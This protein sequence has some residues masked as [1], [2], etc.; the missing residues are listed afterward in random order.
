MAATASDTSN[1][2]AH[3]ST[4]SPTTQHPF[5]TAAGRGTLSPSRLSFYLAMDRNF[6]AQAYPFLGRLLA[7]VP[8]SSLHGPDSAVGRKN[9]RI[10]RIITYSLTN[11]VREVEFFGIIAERYGLNLNGWPENKATRDYTA[12]MARVGAEGRIEDGSCSCG[13]W[14][15]C[16]FHY[17][18][19][20][21]RYVGSLMDGAKTGDTTPAVAVL[22]ENWTNP[23]FARFVDDVAELVN[24]LDIR[25]GSDAYVRAEQIWLRVVELEEAFWPDVGGDEI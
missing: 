11:V 21:W 8:F 24:S 20:A 13:P 9:A 17:Y 6:V 19:D 1:L 15:G 22:V 10:V 12:E 18:F 5:L 14:S 16:V 7:A 2:T 4:L 25:P 23:E 3:L